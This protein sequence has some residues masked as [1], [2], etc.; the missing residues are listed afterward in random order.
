MHGLAYTNLF[1]RK[2]STTVKLSIQQT[3]GDEEKLKALA[4]K[5]LPRF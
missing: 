3:S 2:G 5:A 4:R 1:V